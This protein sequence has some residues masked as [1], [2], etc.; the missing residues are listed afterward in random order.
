MLTALVRTEDAFVSSVLYEAGKM[1]TLVLVLVLV[2]V[3]E[4]VFEFALDEVVDGK[5][6]AMA[7]TVSRAVLLTEGHGAPAGTGTATASCSS[8]EKATANFIVEAVDDE[9]RKTNERMKR[10]W[11]RKD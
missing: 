9:K 4:L 1:L 3:F 5:I 2:L 8:A 10:S 11:S 7:A 6:E